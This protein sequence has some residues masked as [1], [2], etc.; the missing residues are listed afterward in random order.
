MT[1]TTTAL[2]GSR[3]LVK[4]QDL[5]GAVGETVLDSSQWEEINAH[6]S[7][8]QAQDEYAA[9]VDEFFK[10]LL[11]AAEK[12]E[13]VGIVAP[14][15]LTYVVLHEG[16]EGKPS[17]QEQRVSLTQDSQILR[18]LDS[19]NTDRLI[20]VG[21]ELEIAATAVV[22]AGTALVT[23]VDAVAGNADASL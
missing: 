8:D 5:N 22:P 4:G 16:E 7:F 3:V 19:G 2:T 14:D 9:V 1:F 10:P 11:E 6:R 20:W 18:L 21:D 12:A 15:P 23:P 17:R 13:K